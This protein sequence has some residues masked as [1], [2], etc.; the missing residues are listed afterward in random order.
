[1]SENTRGAWSC[2][3]IGA[4][5]AHQ[6]RYTP[7][8]RA[9]FQRTHDQMSGAQS[10]AKQ[11]PYGEQREMY[12]ACGD[13]EDVA[14]LLH[15]LIMEKDVPVKDV[16]HRMSEESVWLAS[17]QFCLAKWHFR[18]YK[19]QQ[20]AARLREVSSTELSF[21]SPSTDDDALKVVA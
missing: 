17:V 3:N 13:E 5:E 21:L 10:D 2:G 19:E 16:D 15:F 8:L 6:I 14:E 12:L 7:E 20:A 4:H 11:F 1:M 9:I 18:A